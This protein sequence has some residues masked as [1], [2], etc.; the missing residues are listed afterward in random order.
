M[1][2]AEGDSDASSG[3]GGLDVDGL[4]ATAGGMMGDDGSGGPIAISDNGGAISTFGT[5]A[6]GARGRSTSGVSIVLVTGK[7]G[8]VL[9]VGDVGGVR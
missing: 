3:G 1:L 5:S 6:L 7:E 4:G 8:D 9:H 2:H